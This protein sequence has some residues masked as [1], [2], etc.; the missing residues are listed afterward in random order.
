MQEKG[1]VVARRKNFPCNTVIGIHERIGRTR[2]TGLT[3]LY[4]ITEECVNCGGCNY[5]AI[6]KLLCEKYKL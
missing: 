6:F 4:E 3:I 1:L 5:S 2:E